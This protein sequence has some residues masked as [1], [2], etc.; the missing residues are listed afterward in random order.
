MLSFSQHF[1]RLSVGGLERLTAGPV[2]SA[3]GGCLSRDSAVGEME[4]WFETDV[5]IFR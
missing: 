4:K 5:Q 1:H 2:G 3:V